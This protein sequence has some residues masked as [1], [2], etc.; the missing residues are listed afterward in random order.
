MKNDIINLTIVFGHINHFSS[1][2][3]VGTKFFGYLRNL[4]MLIS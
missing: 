2:S 4:V 1:I 3:K